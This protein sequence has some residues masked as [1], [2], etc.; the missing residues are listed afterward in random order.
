MSPHPWGEWDGAAWPRWTH[1][2]QPRRCCPGRNV[3]QR[4]PE[5]DPTSW[6]RCS[7][8]GSVLLD[9][10]EE[11]SVPGGDAFI[12]ASY[13]GAAWLF[14]MGEG[15]GGAEHQQLLL[16]E[17]GERQPRGP[18]SRWELGGRA[19]DGIQAPLS[20]SVS[21]TLGL[22]LALKRSETPSCGELGGLG[23]MR[24]GGSSQPTCLHVGD[25]FQLN[26]W[27]GIFFFYQLL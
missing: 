27:D 22:A 4:S 25:R 17:A 26:Y 5:P 3:P 13:S 11:E 8:P 2:A 24:E 12:C 15:S 10:R 7:W 19:R 23:G 18:L 9:G 21:H 20:S 16:T 1:A 6:P 14:P